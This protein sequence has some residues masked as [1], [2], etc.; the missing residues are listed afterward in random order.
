M[1]YMGQVFRMAGRIAKNRV[2]NHSV[3]VYNTAPELV[4]EL[5]SDSG[6]KHWKPLA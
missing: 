2:H 3:F 1:T 5:D 6:E 4:R